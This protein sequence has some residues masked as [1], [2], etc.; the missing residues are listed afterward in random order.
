MPD[1]P[2]P[3]VQPA[4][5][6]AR[7]K[8]LLLLTASFITQYQPD[9]FLPIWLLGLSGLFAHREMRTSAAIAMVRGG[10]VFAAVWF[11]M[12]FIYLLWSGAVA[13]DAARYALSMAARLLALALAGAAFARLS[14]P[15]D[16]GRAASWFL[17]PFLG[18]HAWKAGLSLALVAWFLPTALRLLGEVN[19]AMKMRRIKTGWRKKSLL[20]CGTALRLMEKKA[21]EL[22]LGLTSRELDRDGVWRM[23]G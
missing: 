23:R 2:R 8:L 9:W 6:D 21:W 4:R 16:T 15:I 14:P 19:A 18:R 13:A 12:L 10:A 1:S 22:A 17:R 3:F 20:L 5:L 7:I 11:M